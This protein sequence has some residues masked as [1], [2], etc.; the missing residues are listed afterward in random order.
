MILFHIMKLLF[1]ITIKILTYIMNVYC[2]SSFHFLFLF[3]DE[4]LQMVVVMRVQWALV[5]MVR[6][7]GALVGEVISTTTAT[8]T[9]IA[10][11]TSATTT[12]LLQQPPLLLLLLIL[13]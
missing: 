6:M 12:I 11:T 4:S 8:T 5:E 13:R 3:Y 9:T 2:M 1:T 10:T 7:I